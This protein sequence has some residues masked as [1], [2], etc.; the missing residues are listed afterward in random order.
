MEYSL[1]NA[2]IDLDA[3]QR[4]IQN[5]KQVIDPGSKFMAVVKADAYG[6]GA[7]RVAQKA[8]KTGADWLGVARPEEAFELRK[9]GID[10]P[11]LVFGYV[12]PAQ[13]AMVNDLDLVVT[14]CGLEMA[15]ALS[16]AARALNTS[17]KAHLKVDTGMGRLGM[18]VGPARTDLSQTLADQQMISKIEEM[19]KLPG[20][21]LDGIYTHFA[22][23]DET[24]RTYTDRQI[25]AFEDLLAAL[26]K[27]GVVFELCHAANSAG[28]LKFPESHFDMVRAGHASAVCCHCCPKRS[29]RLLRQLWHDLQNPGPDP[30]CHDSHR[31]CR[32]VFKTVF[33]QL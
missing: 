12:H 19:V 10:A 9:A 14:V 23:A 24:D 22:A 30:A 27:K 20:L 15:A 31:L 26:E 3:I 17:V 28:I 7:V 13:A 29:K 1:L 11:I 33:I 6:H 4:N 21:E 25:K 16:R 5:L 2:C 8:L 32:R 18:I